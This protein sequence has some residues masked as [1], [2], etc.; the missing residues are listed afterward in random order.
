MGKAKAREE[1]DLTRVRDALEVVEEDGRGL[2]AEFSHLMV[3]RTSLLIDLKVSKD[4]VF[5]L[6][7]QA[8]KDK[9]SMAEE[10]HKALKQIFDYGYGS[11][12]F[13]H[14]IRGDRTRTSPGMPDSVKPLPLEFFTNLG[15]PRAL[16]LVEA[17]AA[18]VLLVETVKD[19]KEGIV[20]EE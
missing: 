16:P 4:E 13:K 6:H 15:C 20:E 17:K 8:S 5:A 14:G 18:E 1:D 11:C 3:E 19:P 9:E 7:S 2:E 12:A 10:Y